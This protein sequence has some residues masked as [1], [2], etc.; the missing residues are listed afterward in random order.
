MDIYKNLSDTVYCDDF[1]KCAH[2]LVDF[3]KEAL[4]NKNRTKVVNSFYER[5]QMH[6]LGEYAFQKSNK[7]YFIYD[8]ESSVNS[9]MAISMPRQE[10]PAK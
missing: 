4:A 1:L 5:L 7:Q 6:G 9:F 3:L 2:K 10:T 8:G